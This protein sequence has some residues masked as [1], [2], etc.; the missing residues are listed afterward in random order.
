MLFRNFRNFD[1]LFKEFDEMFFEQPYL[2]NKENVENG[3]D[4]DGEWE[5]RTYVSENGLFS[6]TYLTKKSK[7]KDELHSLKQDLD[8]CVE[9]QE[10]EKAVE[11]RDKI[12]KLEENKEEL[13]KLNGELNECI[14]NQDF[15]RAIVLRDTIK[16]LK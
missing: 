12:K 3:V 14:K 5:K 7:P 1:R 4:N 6:Y 13:S 9:N 11:L 15:E 10:F 8:T 2:K 16:K